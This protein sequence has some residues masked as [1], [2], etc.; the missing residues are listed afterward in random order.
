MKKIL[1]ISPDYYPSNGG[2]EKYLL[3]IHLYLNKYY[4]NDVFSGT[5][6]SEKIT[7]TNNYKNINVFK[8]ST[9]KFFGLDLLF[10]PLNYL[11]LYVHIKNADIVWLN[12]VKFVFFFSV[13][14]S[15]LHKKRIIFT[16]HGLVFHNQRY[17]IF[18]K[19]FL[20][21]YLWFIKKYIKDVVSNGLSDYEYLLS[22]N[23]N[24]KLINNGV[25]LSN[26]RINRKPLVNNFLYFGRIDFNKGLEELINCAAAYK[27]HQKNFVI[28]ILGSGDS[29]YV[30]SLKKNISSK[31][32]SVNF[33]FHGTYTQKLLLSQLKAAEFVLI[34]SKYES[35]GITLIES[36]AS[37]ASVIAN[38][39]K[40][41][42]L[43]HDDKNAFYLFD[44]NKPHLFFKI[45]QKAR[46]VYKPKNIKGIDFSRYY[47]LENHINKYIHLFNEEL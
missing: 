44:F 47:S 8:Y 11:K 37:G 13:L 14:I 10:N 18:K 27:T 5:R 45:I 35:F 41:F 39:N 21:I 36:L 43:M 40:Q 24:S 42:Q 33:I 7:H 1:T 17:K 9:F 6:I 34:P 23:I 12:D 26:F 2:V 30:K 32:L 22:K 29:N 3:T 4:R 19:F 28:N 15:F 38:N 31:G 25:D 20:I 16:T 46:N